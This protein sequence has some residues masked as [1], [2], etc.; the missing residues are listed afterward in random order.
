MCMGVRHQCE[1]CGI[2]M[3]AALLFTYFGREE[4]KKAVH[5]LKAEREKKTIKMAYN[6]LP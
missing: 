3:R 2:H 5:P 6:S 1:L 4:G